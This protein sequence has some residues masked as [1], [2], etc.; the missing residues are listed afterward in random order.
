MEVKTLNLQKAQRKCD[1]IK[2]QCMECEEEMK[3]IEA[4]L[5]E[6]RNVEFEIGKY[7]A[8]KV[9]MDTK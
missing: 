1:A 8:Q 6:I 9:E 2:A 3:P 4:R 7:Q 5:V